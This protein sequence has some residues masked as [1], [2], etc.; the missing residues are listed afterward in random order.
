MNCLMHQHFPLLG[1]GEISTELTSYLGPETSTS[2][3]T[4]EVAGLTEQPQLSPTEL[5]SR[6]T[7]PSLRLPFLLR[8]S[9]IAK[10]EEA[11]MEEILTV[12]TPMPTS[13]VFQ[14]KHVNNTQLPILRNSTAVQFKSAKTA[15]A[16]H[17]LQANQETVLQYRTTQLLKLPNTVQLAELIK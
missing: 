5:T 10:L 6:E 11:A 14:K 13:M 12:F 1:T 7:T 8:S 2:Q 15:L 4:V 3:S 17:Q 9:S 16:H